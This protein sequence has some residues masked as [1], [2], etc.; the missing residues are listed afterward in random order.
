MG[1]VWGTRGVVRCIAAT[2]LLVMSLSHSCFAQAEVT[3]TTSDVYGNARPATADRRD[4]S[5][6]TFQSQLQRQ[7][8][9][10][11]LTAG[12]RTNQRGGR[13]D[14]VL[15]GDI[16]LMTQPLITEAAVPQG[17]IFPAMRRAFREYGGFGQRPQRRSPAPIGAL[18]Q[19]RHAL[20]QATALNAPVHRA[21]WE[22]GQRG[23]T[24]PA[25][26]ELPALLPIARD[27]SEA[28]G[29]ALDDRLQRGLALSLHRLRLE[30]W[31]WFQEGVYRR[32]ARQFQLATALEPA[33]FES[34]LGEL[35]CYVSVGADLTSLAALEQLNRQEENLFAHDLSMAD[36]FAT[37]DEARNVRLRAQQLAQG[38]PDDPRAVA[39][40][41]LVRWYLDH[42]PEALRTATSAAEVLAETAYADWPAKMRTAQEA[43]GKTGMEP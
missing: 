13:S 17:G 32:A 2:I 41:L 28:P 43:D 24:V 12:L 1:R 31:S 19:R 11:Y 42:R 30:G 26:A 34:R 20:V 40:D 4:L 14:F 3:L 7:A 25:P 22:A 27:L 33:D 29:L 23:I 8:L 18:L 39:L 37:L 35:L 15:P 16:L 6:L 36:R 21:M 38:N 9:E 5:P 10:A